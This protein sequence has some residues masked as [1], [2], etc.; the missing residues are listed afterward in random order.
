MKKNKILIITLVLGILLLTS[1]LYNTYATS[2]GV[3]LGND[4]NTYDILLNDSI[5]TVSV[6][7]KSSKTIYYQFSNTNKG[8][9]KYHIGYSSDNVIAKVWW[10]TE[11]KI[12]D[13]IEQG[14][15]KFIKLKLINDSTSDDTITIKPVLGYVNGGDVIPDSNTMLVTGT[16]NETNT[17]S[18]SPSTALST[19]G[20]AKTAVEEISFIKDNI[21]P[22]DAIGST[23]MNNDGSIKLWYTTSDTEGMYKV[24]IGSDNEITSFATNSA[25]LFAFYSNLITIDFKNIDTSAVTTMQTMFASDSKLNNIDLSNFDTS[26]VT[27]MY[28]MFQNCSN[29]NELNLDHFYTPKLKGNLS[30]FFLGCSKLK[31]IAFKNIDTSRITNM[32]NMFG[33]CSSLIEVDLSDL[34]TSSVTDMSSMFSKTKISNINID[35]SS[36]K[37]MSSMFSGSSASSLN[38]STFDTSEVTDM[39]SMFNGCRSL[40]NLDLSNFDTSSVTNMDR[41]FYNTTIKELNISNFTFGTTNVSQIFSANSYL[42]LIDMRNADFTNTTNN[43]G[44]NNIFGSTPSTVTV[45]LKDTQF[46][47]DFMSNNY[48]TYTN[49]QYIPSS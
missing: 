15:Y 40:T 1:Y 39:S 43:N 25:S 30:R 9:V 11:D 36:A 6:P 47:R 49:V 32:T 34:D 23:N 27:T 31:K 44:D 7:A 37:N 35:T 3:S 12:S 21:V 17:M 10:D 26:S 38:L 45:Y 41:M 42:T 18:I 48:P 28:G 19:L 14:E 2:T 20:I 13:T 24:Y 5:D 4:E 46:N 22:S 29:I 33:G 16:I 8:T